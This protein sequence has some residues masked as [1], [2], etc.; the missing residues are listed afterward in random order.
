MCDISQKK[1]LMSSVY[2]HFRVDENVFFFFWVINLSYCAQWTIKLLLIVWNCA[3][4][5]DLIFKH[6]IG[7]TIINFHKLN[8]AINSW[9]MM[10]ATTVYLNSH[11]KR[12]ALFCVSKTSRT[13]F[14]QL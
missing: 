7:V 2:T 1:L 6:Q 10:F 4:K 14:A 8:T 13:F 5:S 3:E 9:S 11:V 12:F